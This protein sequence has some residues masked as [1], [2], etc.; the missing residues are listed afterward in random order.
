MAKPEIKET[1]SGYEL[2]W[3]DNHITVSVNR[4]QVHNDGR[5]T[6]EIFIKN[7]ERALYPPSQLNFSSTRTRKELVKHLSE[8]YKDNDWQGI[9]DQLCYIIQERSR[10][11]EPVQEAWA[12]D[13]V[14]PPEYILEP[15]LVKNYP[16]VIFGD[17]GTLKSTTALLFSQLVMLPWQD[18]PL[19]LRTP[20]LPQNVLYLDW[21][22]DLATIK[23]QLTLIQRGIEDKPALMVKYRRCAMPLAQ[24]IEEIKKSILSENARIIIVDSLGLAAGGE[25]KEAQPALT[26]FSALRQLEVTSL[27]LAHSPKDNENVKNKSIY[28]S[29]FFQALSRNI[30]EIRKQQDTGDTVAHMALFHKKSAPFQAPRQ[31]IGFKFVFDN[32]ATSIEPEDPKTVGEFLEKMKIKDQLIQ[33]LKSGPKETAEI[34]A[35]IKGSDEK[36]VRSSLSQYVRNNLLVKVGNGYGLQAQRDIN[37]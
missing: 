9:V 12:G 35:E 5:V 21:E 37:A 34:I 16:N 4:L 32:G 8:T 31:P 30:W 14:E 17:P 33:I 36:T 29:M 24:D 25:L 2:L 18:N 3:I 23:W 28:G 15:F 11:G 7:S 20:Q 13:D 26:F 19:N 22:T 6:G 1:A 27:I 10:R